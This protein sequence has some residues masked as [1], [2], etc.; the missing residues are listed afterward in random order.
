MPASFDDILAAAYALNARQLEAQF[1][2]A[3]YISA[4]DLSIGCG[5]LAGFHRHDAGDLRRAF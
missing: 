3:T 2:Q 5:G 4:L 1:A